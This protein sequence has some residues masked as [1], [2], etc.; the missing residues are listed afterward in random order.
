MT[1]LGARQPNLLLVDDD[2]VFCRALGLALGR[3]GFAVTVA[4]DGA[5]ALCQARIESPDYAVVDLNLD[6]DS[7]LRLI[8]SLLTLDPDIRIVVLT[9]YASLATAVDAIKL[10]AINY[11]AK[12]ADADEVVAALGATA[13]DAAAPISTRP[14][15]VNRLEW[16]HIQRVLRDNDG[17]ISATA[18]QL[19]MHRRT[20]Q[21][22]LAKRPAPR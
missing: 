19:G 2:P 4:H 5:A 7:G 11:L 13:G 1:T 9:G 20:L 16:E 14:L 21:R 6:G 12:P 15:S 10:G 18:R 17:N 8:P 22:K 3:R